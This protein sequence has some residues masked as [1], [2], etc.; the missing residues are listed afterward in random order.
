MPLFFTRSSRRVTRIFPFTL[1]WTCQG[2]G[3]CGADNAST[4]SSCGGCGRSW[5]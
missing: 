2:N 1:G 3:G 5:G 4:A